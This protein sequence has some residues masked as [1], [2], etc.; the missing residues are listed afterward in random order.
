MAD[1]L[2]SIVVSYKLDI[3]D[4]KQQ[5]QDFNTLLSSL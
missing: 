3:S 1:G 4:A 5:L 2:E